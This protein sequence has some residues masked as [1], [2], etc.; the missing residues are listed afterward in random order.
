MCFLI[1]SPFKLKVLS[2]HPLSALLQEG[3]LL[4][5]LPGFKETFG[6]MFSRGRAFKEAKE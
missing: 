6:D 1:R 3:K 4:I 5:W 2:T